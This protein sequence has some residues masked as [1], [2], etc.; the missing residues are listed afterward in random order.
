MND[1]QEELDQQQLEAVQ[2]RAKLFYKREA[3]NLNNTRARTVR[4][5][6]ERLNKR[7]VRE[8]RKNAVNARQELW[9]VHLKTGGTIK[10]GKPVTREDYNPPAWDPY[11]VKAEDYVVYF[12]KNGTRK[13]SINKSRFSAE[14]LR[15]FEERAEQEGWKAGKT[16]DLAL[17][18]GAEGVTVQENQDAEVR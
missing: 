18:E 14:E 13:A 15:A 6:W 10:N 16:I 1:K 7:Q 5:A 8:D 2:E 11:H 3:Q 12:D 17:T 4:R 9:D